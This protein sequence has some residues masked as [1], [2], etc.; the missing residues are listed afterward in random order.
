METKAMINKFMNE[1]IAGLIFFPPA[2]AMVF[3]L[4]IVRKDRAL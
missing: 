2:L 4:A 3:I 1:I